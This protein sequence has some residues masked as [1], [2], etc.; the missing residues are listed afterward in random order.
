MEKAAICF[1]ASLCLCVCQQFAGFEIIYR[2][3]MIGGGLNSANEQPPQLAKEAWQIFQYSTTTTMT[4]TTATTAA[5]TTSQSIKHS[6]KS[7]CNQIRCNPNS[8]KELYIVDAQVVGH[9][10]ENVIRSFIFLL[11]KFTFLFP[12]RVCWTLRRHSTLDGHLGF[13]IPCRG[14][15][16]GWHCL[17]AP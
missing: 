1:C 8:N 16:P 6:L 12:T 5:A 13:T 17:L 3:I 11:E 10:T 2:K 14:G 4:T 15:W 9:C 7:G